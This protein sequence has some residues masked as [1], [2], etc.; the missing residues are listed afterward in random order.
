VIALPPS[1]RVYLCAQPLDGRK[2]IDALS[3]LVRSTLSLDP[4]S[5]HLFLFIAGRGRCAR[6]LFW[7]HNG[8]VL[9]SKRLEKGHF[10]LPESIAP[11]TSHI[12]LEP[13]ALMMLLEGID[14]STARVRRRWERATHDTAST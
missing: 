8:F 9:Y 5:G 6:I 4:M 12:V 13:A 3:A 11:G 1:V 10:H 2:G 14:L 7:D